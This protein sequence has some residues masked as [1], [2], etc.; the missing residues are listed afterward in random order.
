[1]KKILL[2]AGTSAIAIGTIAMPFLASA[3]M[4]TTTLATQIDNVNAAA[5]DYLAVVITNYWPF[6]L[7]FLVI[8]GILGFAISLV[9]RLFHRA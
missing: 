8:G 1:M 2:L 5:Y 3:Q 9:V 7:G 4:S 6:L